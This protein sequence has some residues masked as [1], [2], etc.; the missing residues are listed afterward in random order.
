MNRICS[1]G[2]KF[3]SLRVDP[4]S[5]RLVLQR[6]AVVEWLERLDYGAESRREA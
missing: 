1:P 6:G 3:Y 5:G 4:F 2:S